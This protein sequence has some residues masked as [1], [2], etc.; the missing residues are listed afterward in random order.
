[1]LQRSL[2]LALLAVLGLSAPVWGAGDCANYLT[3]QF[4]D[5]PDGGYL[6][7]SWTKTESGYVKSSIG[8]VE[9]QFE[10]TETYS[11]GTYR[12]WDGRYLKFD[13]RTYTVMGLRGSFA[14]PGSLRPRAPP[15]GFEKR[16]GLPR[17]SWHSL[18]RWRAVAGSLPP[19]NGRFRSLGS[20]SSTGGSPSD[21]KG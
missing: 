5:D 11:V 9:T 13:C 7:N 16:L 10:Q 8:V 4:Y 12:M 18:S 2:F 1:M 3:T 14:R 20:S 21:P 17:F 6:I 15:V 19:L